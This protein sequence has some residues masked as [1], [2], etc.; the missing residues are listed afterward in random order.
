MNNFIFNSKFYLQIKG[1]AMGAICAPTNIFMTEIKE[2]Y[3]YP[4]IKQISVLC[5]RFIKDILKIWTKSENELRNFMKDLNTKTP[6]NK[7]RF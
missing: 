1:C 4:F 2:K 6:L 5:L 3:I 7:I